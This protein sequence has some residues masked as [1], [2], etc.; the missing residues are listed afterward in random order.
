MGRL[1]REFTDVDIEG[2]TIGIA[3]S[4]PIGSGFGMYGSYAHGFMDT[5]IRT[6]FGEGDFDI[7]TS[8]DF[9]TSYNVAELGFTYTPRS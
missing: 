4:V 5:K 3:A 1:S 7:G 9:D 8:P 6:V 2:P